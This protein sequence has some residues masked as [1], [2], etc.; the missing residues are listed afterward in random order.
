MR[1]SIISGTGRSGTNWLLDIFDG[2]PQ[3]HCRSE[4][5]ALPGTELNNFPLVWTSDAAGSVE[6]YRTRWDGVAAGVARRFGERDHNIRYPKPY[7]YPWS[8]HLRVARAMTGPRTRS[9][10]SIV[11][12]RLV[13]TE[14]DLPW[15]I[16][17]RR[18]QKKSIVIKNFF[19]FAPLLKWLVTERPQ[20][21]VVHI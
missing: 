16:S 17:S 18:R 11:D 10:A 7:L 4:P 15:V 12:R 2:S 8:N 9:V 6:L 14:W 20:V 1:Y 5:H 19:F 13:G 3:T 21:P